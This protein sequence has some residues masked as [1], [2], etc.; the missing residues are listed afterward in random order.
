MI[1]GKGDTKLDPFVHVRIEV[2]GIA[3]I[4]VKNTHEEINDC[5][6]LCCRCKSVCL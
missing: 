6:R 3:F 4:T 5:N 2:C 1:I